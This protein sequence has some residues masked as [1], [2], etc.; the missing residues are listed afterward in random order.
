ML[1][2]QSGDHMSSSTRPLLEGLVFDLRLAL[3]GLRR[4]RAFTLTAITMLALAIGLNAT[5][6]TVMNAMLF[7]GNPLARRS[8]RLAYIDVRRP[9]GQ[10]PAPILYSDFETWRTQANAFEGLAF[11]AGD[12]SVA[13]RDGNGRPLDTRAS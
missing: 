10:A 8:D 7:R 2:L 5:V 6:F 9:S 3:R 13:F 4:D 1:C 11:Q 12:S